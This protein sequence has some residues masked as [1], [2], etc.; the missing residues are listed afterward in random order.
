ME[1]GKGGVLFARGTWQAPLGARGL[2][3]VPAALQS[4]LNTWHSILLSLG[5]NQGPCWE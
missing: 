2:I 3:P 4:Q 5:L 1:N